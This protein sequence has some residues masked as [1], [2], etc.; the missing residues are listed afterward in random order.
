MPLLVSAV[1]LTLLSGVSGADAGVTPIEK[2]ITLLEDMKSNVEEEGKAEAAEYDKYACFCKKTTEAKST[3]I[4]D[5]NDKIDLLSADIAEKS[6]SKKED[7][8]ELKERKEKQEAL[9]SK[10]EETVTRCAKEKAEYEAEAADLAKA[11]SSLK[12]AIKSLEDTKP[13]SLLA[14]RQQLRQTLELADAMNMVAAPKRKVVASLLQNGARVDPSDPEYKYH[15]ND[16]I[17]LLKSLLKDFSSQK[18]ELDAEY[19]KTKQACDDLKASLKDQMGANSEAMNMLEESIEKLAK[20]IAKARSDLVEAQSDLKD[21]EDYLKDLTTGCEARAT[22]YDQRSSMR[23]DEI[24]AISTALK[25]LNDEVKPAT[26]VNKRAL[27]LQRMMHMVQKSKPAAVV[28]KKLPVKVES[29]SVSLLQDS[30]TKGR[31]KSFLRRGALSLEQRRDKALA[32]LN[33]EGE[34]LQSFLLTSLAA[35]AAADPFKKVKNLIQKLIERLL[36]ESRNEATKKG[37][38]DT[39]VGKAE[40]DRD[41]RFEE[42]KALNVDLKGLEVKEEALEAEIKQLTEELEVVEKSLK[43]ANAERLAEKEENLATIKTGKEGL[44]AVTEALLVLRSFYKQAAKAAFVQASPVD[45]D[46]SGPGFSGAYKGQRTSKNAVVA[47][48]ETIQS[49][50]ERTIRTTEADEE[51]AVRH[52]VE[53]VQAAESSIGS[54]T[55]KK[56]LDEQDLKTTKTAIKTKTEDL[57]TAIGLLDTALKELEELKP[58]CIDTGMSYE[59]RVQK[60]EDEMAA[61]KKA[62]C[63]LDEEGVEP[64]CSAALE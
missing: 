32:T 27:L 20:E 57:K 46:T 33:A 43:D 19:A 54:K 26:E 2:V 45:E 21:D 62:L 13:A 44:E 5:G 18:K 51:A 38:C 1:F 16:I 39:E 6:E 30:L 10:L 15:S 63:I 41:F 11:I 22:D 58:T 7:E 24:E 56:E 9:S 8:T 61:L 28:E 14:V 35:R 12:N 37:F 23:A 42:A 55:T 25:I 53:F 40:K 60:R 4:K 36:A 49:D 52:H 29:K 47:L 31:S 34:R 59:E 64:E 48:L 50:F 3:S 17:D